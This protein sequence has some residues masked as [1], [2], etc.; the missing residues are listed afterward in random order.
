M[1]EA[2]VRR[3]AGRLPY[4]LAPFRF[5][6]S[7]CNERCCVHCVQ[8]PV[9]RILL[10]RPAV[11][12]ACCEPGGTT[13]HALPAAA[14]HALALVGH[15]ARPTARRIA[16]PHAARRS[17]AHLPDDLMIEAT[18]QLRPCERCRA[19]RRASLSPQG[20]HAHGPL[21]RPP[22]G[23]PDWLRACVRSSTEA[24]RSAER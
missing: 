10:Y 6:S 12:I 7:V 18:R 17:H 11:F 23:R 4:E 2:G 9:K 22:A 8:S 13:S 1:R 19:R 15:Q 16:R 20:R 3:P 5:S 21:A 14:L 24:I